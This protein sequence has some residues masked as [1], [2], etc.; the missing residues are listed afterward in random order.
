MSCEFS[1]GKGVFKKSHDRQSFLFSNGTEA[2]KK[3]FCHELR[4]SIS[5]PNQSGKKLR[6][7]IGLVLK[8]SF[9]IVTF[10]NKRV[11]KVGGFVSNIR[12]QL[13][14]K[15]KKNVFQKNNQI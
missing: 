9:E 15:P 13:S 1:H 5:E 14:S 6:P 2:A 4:L 10:L 7:N 12:E 3:P 8:S 11:F